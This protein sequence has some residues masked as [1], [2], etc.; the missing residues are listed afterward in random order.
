M[1]QPINPALTGTGCRVL[2][3]P[4]AKDLGWVAPCHTW[5]KNYF[6]IPHSS[7]TQGQMCP[8]SQHDLLLVPYVLSHHSVASRHLWLG[9]WNLWLDHMSYE[10]PWLD[11]LDCPSLCLCHQAA[12]W[13]QSFFCKSWDTR[14]LRSAGEIAN[15][16]GWH[17]CPCC[18][19]SYCPLAGKHPPRRVIGIGRQSDPGLLWNFSLELSENTWKTFQQ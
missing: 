18:E 14:E 7:L 10:W 12:G 16:P 11:T 6:H 15:T 13:F 2:K 1:S 5:T 17:P 9:P 8:H 19:P 3:T 4:N